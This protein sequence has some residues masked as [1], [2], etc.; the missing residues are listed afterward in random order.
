MRGWGGVSWALKRVL[1]TL[2]MGSRGCREETMEDWA[3]VGSA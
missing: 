2:Q 3:Q 1:H